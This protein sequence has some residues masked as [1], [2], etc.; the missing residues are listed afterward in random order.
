MHC[1]LPVYPYQYAAKK[2]ILSLHKITKLMNCSVLKNHLICFQKFSSHSLVQTAFL[3][4]TY[5]K[6]LKAAGRYMITFHLMTF[7]D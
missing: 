3:K 7:T 1:Y 6:N 5:I 2:K 4:E